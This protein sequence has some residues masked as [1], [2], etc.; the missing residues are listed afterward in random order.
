MAEN[1]K[2]DLDSLTL[3]EIMAAEDASGI[4]G[5]KLLKM[6]GHRR[7]LALFVNRLRTSGNAPEWQELTSLRLLDASPGP[8]PS[9][10][11]SP[12]QTSNVSD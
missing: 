6:S 1:V 12:S 3:G 5:S 2:L 11:D 9:P 4:D 10:V 7:V 8:S